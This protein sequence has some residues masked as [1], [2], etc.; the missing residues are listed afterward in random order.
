MVRTAPVN[1]VSFL[2]RSA[3]TV[4][5]WRYRCATYTSILMVVRRQVGPARMLL[6]GQGKARALDR[7]LSR[8]KMNLTFGSKTMWQNHT[9]HA[10][11]GADGGHDPLLRD[12]IQPQ[13]ILPSQYFA[14]TGA[15]SEIDGELRL[16]LAVLKDGIRWFLSDAPRKHRLVLEAQEWITPPGRTGPLTFDSICEVVG[17]EAQQLRHPP[18]S[19]RAQ[20]GGSE[21]P[22]EQQ[23]PSPSPP[24]R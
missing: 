9:D 24:A 7:T 11:T 20:L 22:D 10:S 15:G 13:I 21:A 17:I 18:V 6:D 19:L 3:P 4:P 16:L 12:L 8:A 5:F 1:S 14:R 23:P 2:Y